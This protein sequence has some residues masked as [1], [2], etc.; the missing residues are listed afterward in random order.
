MTANARAVLSDCEAALGD[1]RSGATGLL[2]RTRWVSVV[3]LLRAVGHVLDK[4]DGRRDPKLKAVIA[5]AY[6]DLKSTQPEPSI[7]WQFIEQERNNV[8][9]A[10]EFGVQQNVTVRP[11]ALWHDTRTGEWGSTESGPTTYE[12]LVRDGPFAGQD[13][14]DVVEQA[15]R[16][17]HEYLD[18]LDRATN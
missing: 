4:V 6:A 17:W 1:L 14:R 2:W 18:A 9:K 8:I 16:W 12:H 10:Y 15:I 11:G 3:T 5:S 7:Y 13:P